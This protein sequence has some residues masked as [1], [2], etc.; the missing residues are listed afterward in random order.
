MGYAGVEW[1]KARSYGKNISQ[2]GADVANFLGDVFLGIYHMNYTSL[3]KADWSDERHIEVVVGADMATYDNDVLTRIVVLAHDRML[4]V[5]LR[6]LAPGYVKLTFHRRL[7]REGQLWE[8]MPT[9]EEH[10]EAL[11]AHYGAAKE[12]A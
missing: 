12:I 7:K 6:G 10:T 1:I 2:L 5:E 9:L 4:R 11:R 3:S 8:R